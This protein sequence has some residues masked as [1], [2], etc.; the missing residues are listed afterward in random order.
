MRLLLKDPYRFLY[1]STNA[2]HFAKLTISRASTRRVQDLY[3][4]DADQNGKPA[5]VLKIKISNLCQGKT[6]LVELFP[7]R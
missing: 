4:P 3:Q 2:D 1:D 6:S 7:C 5:H